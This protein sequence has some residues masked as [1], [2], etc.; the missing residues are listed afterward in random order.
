MES[1][2]TKRGSGRE[3]AIVLH[4]PHGSP[5]GTESGHPPQHVIN[6]ALIGA[7]NSLSFDEAPN[8]VNPSDSMYSVSCIN[9]RMC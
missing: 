2:L 4:G 8:A 1:Q 7:H 3:L 9:S 6:L 5:D